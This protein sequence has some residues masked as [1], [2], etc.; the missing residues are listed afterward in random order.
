M[1]LLWG[2]TDLLVRRTYLK[3]AKSDYLRN[4]KVERVHAITR[5]SICFYAHGSCVI[6]ENVVT[7][8]FVTI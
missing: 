8:Q 7:L 3:E 5:H 6:E 4:N 2:I 1:L